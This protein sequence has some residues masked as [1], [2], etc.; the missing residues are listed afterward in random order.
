[1]RRCVF[2]ICSKCAVAELIK[3]MVEIF[4]GRLCLPGAERATVSGS[5][6]QYGNA[7]I[8]EFIL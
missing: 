1:M 6:M 3:V 5:M 2:M 7:E 4:Q 8:T